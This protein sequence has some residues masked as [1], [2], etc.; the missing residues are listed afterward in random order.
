MD[1]LA[2]ILIYADIQTS[3]ISAASVDQI[4]LES[5]SC[6][7][8]SRKEGVC[9]SFRIAEIVSKLGHGHVIGLSI[10]IT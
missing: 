6:D 8:A 10:L 2:I 5:E 4:L 1:A 3:D 9:R 7:A